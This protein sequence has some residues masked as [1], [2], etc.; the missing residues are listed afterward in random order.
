MMKE[1]KGYPKEKYSLIFADTFKGQDN[2]TLKELCY[3]NN[4]EVVIVSHN[5]TNKFQP[6]DISANKPAKA[7][8]QNQY[9]GWF[10][11]K[12]SVQL[13]KV[14]D[15]TDI[16]ITSKLSNLKPSHTSWIVDLYK[17]LLDNQEIVVNSFDSAGISEAVTKASTILYKIENS[18]RE[19]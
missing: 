6:L 4:C 14:I 18:C 1:E 3:R 10:S 9:N 16:K 7:F 17:H 5:L 19:V 12:V 8:I 13:K 15:P 2:N 11:S